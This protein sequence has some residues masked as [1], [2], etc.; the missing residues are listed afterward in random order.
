MFDKELYLTV[1]ISKL[2][3]KKSLSSRTQFF[4]CESNVA[5]RPAEFHTDD[6]A[7]P[8]F[9]W[10]L[11]FEFF[12]SECKFLYRISCLS[13]LSQERKDLSRELGVFDISSQLKLK[14]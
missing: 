6:V 7:L 11:G 13:G 8:R 2:D 5:T 4:P 3:K 12:D 10:L 14:L 1:I 9:Y